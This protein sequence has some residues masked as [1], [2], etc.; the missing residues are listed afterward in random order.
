[1]IEKKYNI[2][3]DKSGESWE[4]YVLNN[5]RLKLYV[6]VCEIDRIYKMFHKMIN[7]KILQKNSQTVHKMFINN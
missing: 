4:Q 7:M 5:K 1:M 6:C 3:E 2:K